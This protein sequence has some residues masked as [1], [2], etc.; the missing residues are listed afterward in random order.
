MD[1]SD[2]FI[3]ACD[4]KGKFAG[5]YIIYYK[6]A[7]G[8]KV[9]RLEQVLKKKG[10]QFVTTKYNRIP[11]WHSFLITPELEPALIAKWEKFDDL[12]GYKVITRETLIDYIKQCLE[13][14]Q[15]K[16]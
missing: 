11:L 9:Y 13:T 12:L 1:Y 16:I 2:L 14:T 10:S 6:Q 4:H 15:T 8:K 3:P 5:R 7:Q